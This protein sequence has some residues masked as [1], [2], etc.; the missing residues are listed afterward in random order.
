MNRPAADG[1]TAM[2]G[3]LPHLQAIMDDPEIRALGEKVKTDK[4]RTLGALSQEAMP[5]IAGKH[6]KELFAIAAAVTDKTP[7]EVE[8]EPLADA[9][10]AF[11]GALGNEIL[12]F[13]AFCARLVLSF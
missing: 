10:A 13:F 3:M 12:S 2:L 8:A 1:L 11:Q 4:K 7:E 9:L 6:R 5:L